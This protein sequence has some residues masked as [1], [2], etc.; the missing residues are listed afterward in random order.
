[1]TGTL[2]HYFAFLA[3]LISCLGLLGLAI[4]TAEQRTKEI[5]IR[6]VLG[7]GTAQLFILLARDFLLLV[8]LA[9][10]IASPVAAWAMQ[11]WLEGYAYH[12]P[13][14]GA[15]FVGAGLMAFAIA[16]LTVG[17]HAVRT[18]LANPV[19]SLRAE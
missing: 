9:F 16:L 3:I 12:A 17:Y 5:G 10:V 13:L 15:I 8:L 1:V 6:K 2:S 4:F 7:A 19:K 14:S 18:A 11:R